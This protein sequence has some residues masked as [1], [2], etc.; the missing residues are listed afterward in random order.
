M[1][2]DESGVKIIDPIFMFPAVQIG[3]HHGRYGLFGGWHFCAVANVRIKTV[4]S[5]CGITDVAL[6]RIIK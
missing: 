6:F 4:V 5:L 3:D 1:E 2:A